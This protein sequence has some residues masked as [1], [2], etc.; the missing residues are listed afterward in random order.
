MK[1]YKNVKEK[2]E[3]TRVLLNMI[4]QMQNID[5]RV[6]LI[7]ALTPI[8]LL[9]A[10]M[11]LEDEVTQLAGERYQRNIDSDYYRWGRQ[12]GSIY[13]GEQKFPVDVPRVR[14][15]NGRHEVKLSPTSRKTFNKTPIKAHH[16]CIPILQFQ[17]VVS[18]IFNLSTFFT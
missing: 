12:G 3:G 6:E 16:P 11:A 10:Q 1:N 14:N 13:L 17:F 9:N 7:Q 5:I 15:K 8:G 18:K 2:R 4:P